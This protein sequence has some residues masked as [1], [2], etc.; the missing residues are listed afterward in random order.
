MAVE[1]PAQHSP[2][3]V[4]QNSLD[5]RVHDL[6]FGVRR[7]I[8][9]HNHRRRFFDGFDRFVKVLSVV[10]G[11]G[12]VVSAISSVHEVTIGLAAVIAFLSAISL[13]VGPAQA[14]RLHEELAKRFSGLEH[15]IALTSDWTANRLRKFEADRLLIE[16]EEPPI[17]R[18]L[19][20]Q[21]HNELCRAMGYHDCE[22]VQIDPL[23]A[24]FS[25]IVDLWPS[26]I[27][28]KKT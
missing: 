23:Q 18:V 2:S 7:S 22:F 26:R 27:K 17:M 3:G 6:L 24:F 9:Y 20:S 4:S 19:D 14:A 10:G 11:S 1:M 25:Q 16:A 8:R 21:C 12:A 5:E 15:A 28:R 13:I